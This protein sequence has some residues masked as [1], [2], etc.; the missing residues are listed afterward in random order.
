[1]VL[2]ALFGVVVG[3]FMLRQQSVM[4]GITAHMTYNT[5]VLIFTLLIGGV[6]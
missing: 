3:Y 5:M 1:M 2:A 6:V 4:P